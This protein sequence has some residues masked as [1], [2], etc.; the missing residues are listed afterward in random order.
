MKKLFII[1]SM[2]IFAA[3]AF[4]EI[5]IATGSTKGTYY[6]IGNDIA[7]TCGMELYPMETKGSVQNIEELIA[8]PKVK[9]A[10]VQNDVLNFFKSKPQFAKEVS[11]IKMVYPFYTEEIHIVVRNGSNINS[12]S[13][14][15]NKKIV[16]GPQG[17]GSWLTGK[18]MNQI[19]KVNWV[20]IETDTQEGFKM[21]IDKQVDAVLYVAGAPVKILKDL[22]NVPNA[23]KYLKVLSIQ[24]PALDSIYERKTIPANTYKWYGKNIN[25]YTT[26]A[27]LI[28][29]DYTPDKPSY[30]RIKT[31]FNC[32]NNNLISLQNGS[33][34]PKW[35][36]IDF[37]NAY[38]VKWDIS[39]AVKEVT[40]GGNVG[41]GKKSL[42]LSGNLN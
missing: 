13:D 12:F 11:Q 1:I 26:R 35:K 4:A 39:S 33:G 25:T 36:E 9:F 38:K 17:S 2:V 19:S 27:V 40:R 5:N 6:A 34:H 8:N 20:E 37:A 21:L 10:I 28:S 14:L 16:I 31:M 29:Y 24:H 18:L 42:N 15:Y 41:V 3:T 30:G 7:R 32:I 23:G 22:D